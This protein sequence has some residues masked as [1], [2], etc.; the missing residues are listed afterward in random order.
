[1]SIGEETDK[2]QSVDLVDVDGDFDLDAVFGNADGTSS[3][4]YNVGGTLGPVPEVV[5]KR[6]P[7]SEGLQL[8][9]DFNDDGHPDLLTG[10]DIVLGDGSGDFSN[11]ERVPYATAV[12][13]RRLVL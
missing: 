1:V 13:W 7:D 10:G 12:T 8:V 4:Y 6:S 3:T 2:S 5:G 11:G 9:A